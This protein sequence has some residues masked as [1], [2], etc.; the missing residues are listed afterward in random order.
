MLLMQLDYN[1]LLV[2]FSRYMKSPIK[3]PQLGQKCAKE[4]QALP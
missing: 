3:K 4:L 1:D 2:L